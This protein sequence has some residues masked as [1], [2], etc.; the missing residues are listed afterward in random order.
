MSSGGAEETTTQQKRK[1]LVKLSDGIAL[2]RNI[3]ANIKKIKKIKS[4]I[5][6][7]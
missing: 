3:E 1:E 2:E 7:N 6:G 4:L 5:R